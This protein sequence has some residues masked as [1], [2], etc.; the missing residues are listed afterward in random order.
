MVKFSMLQK[1]GRGEKMLWEAV[2][3]GI[4]GAALGQWCA[5]SVMAHAGCF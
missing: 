1:L 3:L 2:S 4:P 5:Q